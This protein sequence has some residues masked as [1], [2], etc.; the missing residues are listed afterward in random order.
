MFFFGLFSSKQNSSSHS[1]TLSI[2]QV[3]KE[4]D[5]LDELM[6]IGTARINNKIDHLDSSSFILD[7]VINRLQSKKLNTNYKDALLNSLYSQVDFL[8]Q[9]SLEKN[10]IIKTLT[11]FINNYTRGSNNNEETMSNSTLNETS[12]IERNDISYI[13]DPSH[14]NDV[15]AETTIEKRVCI[16]DQLGEIRSLKQSEYYNSRNNNEKYAEWENHTTGFGRKIMKKMGYSGGGLGKLENGIV[17]PIAATKKNGFGIISPL[18]KHSYINRGLEKLST[19]AAGKTKNS[20]HR[21]SNIITPWPKNT[22]L[23]T[24]SSIISGIDENRLRK[25]KAKVRSFPGARIDDMYDYLNPL[26]KKNPTN[27]ILHIGSNDAVNKTADEI[28]IEIENLKH[29]IEEILPNV[30]AFLSRPVVRFDNDQA[31]VLLR[32]LDHALQFIPNVICNDNVDKSCVGKKGLHL[33]AKGS[34]RLAINFISLMQSL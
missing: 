23:I 30:R 4:S 28:S 32:Q 17:S 10:V 24:G 21:I 14:E 11:G 8:R 1:D 26:L 13:S 20:I 33:N 29:H 3:T 19:A 22:T 12:H 9:E 25:Y 7:D 18:Q 16:E 5:V 31:N 34:G 2:E 6:A 15:S 27:I